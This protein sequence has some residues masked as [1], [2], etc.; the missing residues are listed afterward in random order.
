MAGDGND[1]ER[2]DDGQMTEHELSDGALERWVA[3]LRS[4]D[5]AAD[6]RRVGWLTRQAADE[7]TLVGVLADL[8]E[9]DRPVVIELTTGRHLRGQITLLSAEVCALHSS[10]GAD[11]VVAVD[12]ICAVRPLPGE[13]AVTGDR[14]APSAATFAEAVSALCPPGTRVALWCLGGEAI[15]GRVHSVGRDVMALVLDAGERWA[16]VALDS[17]V[18][19]SVAESG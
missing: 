19:L 18:E 2:V 16:Y 4:R 14:P 15:T 3:D 9:R 10:Q 7:A 1:F 11:L 13:V 5:A 6:R 12:A 17:V 8:A